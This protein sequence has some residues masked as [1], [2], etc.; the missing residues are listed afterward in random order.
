MH[1]LL[2]ERLAWA[3]A[4]ARDNVGTRRVLDQVDRAY[5]ARSAGIV[6]PEWV[7]WLDRKEID[8]MAGRCLIE[9]GKPAEAEPLISNAVADYTAEHARDVAF[10]RTWIAE[11]FARTHEL[12]AAGAELARARKVGSNVHSSRLNARIETVARMLPGQAKGRLGR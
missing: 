4:R 9:L 1:T 12:D 7:Y 6:E 2:L 8:V 10:Y 11:S 3:S 5:E